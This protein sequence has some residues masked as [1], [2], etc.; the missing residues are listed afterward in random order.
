MEYYIQGSPERAEEIKAAFEKLGYDTRT[1]DYS[2]GLF[3][4][5]NS[6]RCVHYLSYNGL[7]GEIF[8]TH[9]D[10]KELELSVRPKFK[11]GNWITNGTFT[12]CIVSIVNGFY[13]FY[14]GGYLDF[15]K[16]D[17]YYHLWTIQDAKDGDVITNGKLIVIFNK[18]EEPTY[19]Q[20]IIAYAGLDLCDRLQIT[21]GTWQLGI[22][23]AIPA[24]KEQHE[25]LFKKM[26]EAG[27]QWDDKKKELRKIKPHYDICRFKPFDKVLV[28][29]GDMDFWDVDL[30]ARYCDEFQCFRGSWEQCIPF[31][32]DTKFLLDTT[33][34][35]DECYINW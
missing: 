32:D 4:T 20:H 9:P 33:H 19:K 2:R 3:I 12:H 22:D 29:D 28:R 24:N 30:F 11:V 8:K 7:I 15:G 14:G 23:K 13:Y 6:D 21:K 26:K 34:I 1:F 10:Y 18:L 27:Y 25:L 35:P 5:L 31:N 16:I 17:G